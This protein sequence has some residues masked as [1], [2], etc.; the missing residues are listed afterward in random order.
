MESVRTY[1]LGSAASARAALE[2]LIPT[3]TP[4]TK[5]QAPTRRPDQKRAKP[6]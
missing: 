4:Q 5:L 3:D 1:K 6:V 2:P